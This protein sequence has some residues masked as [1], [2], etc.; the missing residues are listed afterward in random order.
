MYMDTLLKAPLI[1]I[2]LPQLQDP[3]FRQ[4]VVLIVEHNS[5]G[6]MGFIVNRP[7]QMP[8]RELIMLKGLD[9][10][11]TIP[12]WFGGPVG[13]DNGLVLRSHSGHEG[14]TD[15]VET[16]IFKGRISVSASIAV[17]KEMVQ[18]P[19]TPQTGTAI[20]SL[21]YPYRFL[22][23]YAGWGPRQLEGEFKVGAWLQ[24]PLDEQILFNTPWQRMWESAIESI[25]I[26][27]ASFVHAPHSYLN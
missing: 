3:N 19:L 2:A 12:A 25:G 6:T 22:V 13:T 7:S 17:L 15:S 1:I 27:P 24:I 5:S 10:P 16:K 18:P 11:N 23:G 21:L 8:V 26:D 4:A 20:P 9:I 14:E